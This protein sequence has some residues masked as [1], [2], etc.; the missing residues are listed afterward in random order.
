[1]SL[2]RYP[3]WPR[4][5]QYILHYLVEY[6]TFLSQILES[7]QTHPR[8]R[9]EWGENTSLLR[10]VV[11]PVLEAQGE[12]MYGVSNR[13]GLPTLLRVTN[14]S[15]R[16]SKINLKEP[17]GVFTRVAKVHS[18]GYILIVQWSR[19]SIVISPLHIEVL[20]IQS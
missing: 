4:K 17:L 11:L 2:Q 1:M 18:R 14:T 9:P 7:G 13:D 5:H 16:G 15:R 20:P 10:C 3:W 8:V 6:F 12:S 19:E